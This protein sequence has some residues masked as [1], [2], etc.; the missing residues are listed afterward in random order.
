MHRM[1]WVYAM[2]AFVPNCPSLAAADAP[3]AASVLTPSAADRIMAKALTAWQVPANALVLIKDGRT[4][5]LKGY[6]VKQLGRP[7]PV[8]AG[9]LFPLASCTKAFTATL[10]GMLVDEGALGWDDLV[11]KHLPQFRLSDPHANAQVS[12][13]DLLTHRTGLKGHDLLW[14]PRPVEPSTIRWHGSR[15]CRSTTPSAAATSTARSCTWRPAAPR[16]G[17]GRAVGENGP[18]ADHRPPRH[19]R[20]CLHL[21]RD[22]KGADRA[23]GHVRDTNGRVGVMAAYET[24]EPNPAGSMHL[25]APRPRRLAQVPSGR[26]RFRR[27]AARSQKPAWVRRGR[28]RTSSG[29][30]GWPGG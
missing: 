14:Y 13:R 5:M 28:R 9:T 16:G 2:L 19:G 15:G 6:G 17:E 25:T 22:P 10:A 24:A 21:R 26:R 4:I 12:V 20:R 7:E 27:Q 1:R 8:T 30:K 29:S 3:E 23:V 18:R 11:Q